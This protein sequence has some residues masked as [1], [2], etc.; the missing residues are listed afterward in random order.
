LRAAGPQET[1][2]E[3]RFLPLLFC[4]TKLEREQRKDERFY[5]FSAI[6]PPRTVLAYCLRE[7]HK[8]RRRIVYKNWKTKRE[9]QRR[10]QESFLREFERISERDV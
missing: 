6:I 4:C 10:N 9:R 1:E 2:R 8:R 7:T 3:K 5:F